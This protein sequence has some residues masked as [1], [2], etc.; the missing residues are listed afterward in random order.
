MLENYQKKF[1]EIMRKLYENFETFQKS[2]EEIPK[3]F[4]KKIDINVPLYHRINFWIYFAEIVRRAFT[5]HWPTPTHRRGWNYLPECYKCCDRTTIEKNPI[6][7][8]HADASYFKGCEFFYSKKGYETSDV[9][10]TPDHNAKGSKPFF[11]DVLSLYYPLSGNI[12]KK[13]F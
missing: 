5:N 2:Y 7:N 13:I 12:S 11:V 3:K 6:H 8:S 4:K 10:K 1:G 9:F